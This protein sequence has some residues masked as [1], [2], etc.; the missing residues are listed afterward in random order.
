MAESK[1]YNN[2]S[3]K[4]LAHLPKLAPGEFIRF[5]LN[6]VKQDKIT[7]KFICPQSARIKSVDRIYDPWAIEHVKGQGATKKVTYEGDYRDIAYILREVPA[8]RDSAKDS[9]IEEGEIIFHKTTAGT[10]EIRGG[11]REKEKMLLF[12]FFTNMNTS[13]IDKPWYV[14]PSGR[15]R[16]H[17]VS[18]SE[19]A[20]AKLNKELTIEQALNL[21]T[22]MGEEEVK[23]LAQGMFPKEYSKM[24]LDA[25]ILKLRDLAKE[26]PKKILNISSDVDVKSTA[27]IEKCLKADYIAID[28]KKQKW[29]W[30]DDKAEICT[31]KGSTPHN[32]LKRYF[33]TD[34]GVEVL[35]QLEK[36]LEGSKEP[37]ETT[38]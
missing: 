38:A 37:E 4:L 16:F 14:K 11:N 21:I 32:S 12:L 17:T 36:L 33:M 2:L 8:P 34:E 24:G 35:A 23:D 28:Q 7:K 19:D 6:N 30:K 13:N 18:P 22:E 5:Q 9:I 26:D 15:G 29:I 10:I 31:I 3:P 20:K 27:F 25:M 1:K